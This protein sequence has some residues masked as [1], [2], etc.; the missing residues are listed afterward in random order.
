MKY[1]FDYIKNERKFEMYKMKQEGKSY[2]EISRVYGISRQRVHHILGKND[3]RYFI[4]IEESL[5]AYKGIRDWLNKNKVSFVKLCRL[6]YGSYHPEQRRR[7]K[8]NLTK[9]TPINIDTINKI[10]DITGLT[11]EQAFKE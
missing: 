11:F 6:V 8:S 5:V 7:L 3:E 1:D 9:K 4:N 10:L 2:A